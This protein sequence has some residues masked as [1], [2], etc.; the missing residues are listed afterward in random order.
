MAEQLLLELNRQLKTSKT[1]QQW[2]ENYTFIP[3]HT[4]KSVLLCSLT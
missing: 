3:P 2:K 4:G 1:I